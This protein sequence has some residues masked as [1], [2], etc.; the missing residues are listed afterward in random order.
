[1]LGIKESCTCYRQAIH[2][3]VTALAPFINFLIM[4]SIW[5]LFSAYVHHYV[6]ALAPFINFLIT[7][8]IWLLF[9]AYEESYLRKLM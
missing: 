4:E 3:Y 6:T 2:H 5:L 9:S 1:M 7:E 8:S